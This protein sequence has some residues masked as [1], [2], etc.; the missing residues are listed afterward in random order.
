[1][2]ERF[3]QCIQLLEQLRLG[4][5]VLENELSHQTCIIIRGELLVVTAYPQMIPLLYIPGKT[6]DSS[7]LVY[8]PDNFRRQSHWNAF[9]RANALDPGEF[10]RP[11]CA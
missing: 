5:H 8:V 6:A 9:Q 3:A 10:L 11:S 4:S 1:M 7:I 2:R